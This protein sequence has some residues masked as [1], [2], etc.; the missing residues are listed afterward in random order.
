MTQAPQKLLDLPIWTGD[1]SV[2]PLVGGRS[3]QAYIATDDKASYVVRFC[4]N[5]PVHH[6]NR[7]H[8]AMV[9]KA[10]AKAGFSPDLVFFE[11]HDSQGIMVFD[12]ITAKT[13]DASD[14]TTNIATLTNRLRDFHHK[15]A[16]QVSGQAHL[17]N[18]FHVISDYIATLGKANS[19]FTDKLETY[20][21]IS[22]QLQEAQ[23]PELIIFGHND[24]VPQ[25]ILQND[26]N[27]WFIDFE[28][29][30]FSTPL[31]D[32]AN[33]ASNAAFTAEQDKELL[34]LYFDATATS[35]QSRAMTALKVALMLRETMW[36]MVSEIHLNVPGV[37]YELYTRECLVALETE[38]DTYQT[39]Y[40]KL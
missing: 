8:E 19:Q 22:D 32:L 17:F 15:V 18:V 2:K 6:V 35:D 33:L 10:S 13:Y 1:V 7:D 24:L 12:F 9:S 3:N 23:I 16:R 34:G 30:A 26:K 5:I 21:K 29:A 38:L 37:D 28:Y 20:Q 40:G 36:S 11:M 14:V 31:S 27:I 25:N 4:H 39:K